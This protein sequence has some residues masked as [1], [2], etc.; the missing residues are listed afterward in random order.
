MIYQWKIKKFA[1]P[2]QKVGEELEKIQERDGSVTPKAI[3]NAARPEGSILHEFFEWKDDVAAERYRERQAQDLIRLIV[4]EKETEPDQKPVKVRAFV[5]TSQNYQPIR[6]VLNSEK[7]TDD[8]MRAARRDMEAFRVKYQ[9]LMELKPV[10]TAIN[11]F[12]GL[13]GEANA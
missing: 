2:A 7:F 6:I 3:V 5:S 9:N 11:E 10:L 13:P 1:T 12:L 8:M 4:V